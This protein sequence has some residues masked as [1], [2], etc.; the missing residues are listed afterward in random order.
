VN[1]ELSIQL[2][3]DQSK[4]EL[5]NAEMFPRTIYST[6]WNCYCLQYLVDASTSL[7]LAVPLI[8]DHID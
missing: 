1:K 2:F 5:M 3:W 6:Y 4:I 7:Q 8:F